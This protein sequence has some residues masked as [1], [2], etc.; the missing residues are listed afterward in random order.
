MNML[1]RTLP[2]SCLIML[3]FVSCTY[4]YDINPE[5][6]IPS[7][8]DEYIKSF[9]SNKCVGCHNS[10]GDYPNLSEI[11]QIENNINKIIDRIERDPGEPGFMP[12]GG[13]KL[14]DCEIDS[15]KTWGDNLSTN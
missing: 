14:N 3:F 1:L 6:N 13:V 8:E 2:L 10:T 15:I 12:L 9:I 11:T 5:C 7:A 4:D